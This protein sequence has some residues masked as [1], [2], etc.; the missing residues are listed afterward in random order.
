MSFTIASDLRCFPDMYHSA[1]SGKDPINHVKLSTLYKRKFVETAKT[2][3]SLVSEQKTVIE[4]PAQKLAQAIYE[5][6]GHYGYNATFN[7]ELNYS[8]TRLI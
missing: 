8:I 4:A 6:D 5:L 7:G 1:L 2:I 3:Y